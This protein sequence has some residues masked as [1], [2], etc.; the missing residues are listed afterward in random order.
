[1]TGLETAGAIASIVTTAVTTLTLIALIWYTVET[2]HLRREAQRQN[3]NSMMPIVVCQ[4]VYVQGQHAGASR[5]VIRNLGSGPAF[6]VYMNSITP[7]GITQIRPM[8]VT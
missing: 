6:N 4:S 2:H 5:P 7:S 8:R 3:E 1:M